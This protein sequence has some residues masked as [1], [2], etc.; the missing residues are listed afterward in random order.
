MGA[1][2]LR[3]ITARR[4]GLRQDFAAV[5]R[6]ALVAHLDGIAGLSDHGEMHVAGG[7]YCGVAPQGAQRANVAMV[8]DQAEAPGMGGRVE[9]YFRRALARFGDLGE[10]SSAAEPTTALQT[11]GPLRFRA[12]RLVANGAALVGDAGGYFDPFT[13]QGVYKAIRSATL[14]ARVAEPALAMGPIT[15]AA[16]APYERRIRAESR[17]GFCVEWLIQHFLNKPHLL[18]RAL[19]A[20]HVRP[21]LADTLVGV[22]GD[23]LP[24]RRVLSPLFLGRLA[25]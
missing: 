20:M 2:G 6:V 23:V 17:P 4:L 7:S 16:L 12:R 13:G 3:G 15:A 25:L 18:C 11:V 9:E 21:A 19:S 24:A 5:R 1:D 8:L 10:R 22:T 14:L